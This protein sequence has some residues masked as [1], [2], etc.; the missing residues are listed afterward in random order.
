MSKRRVNGGVTTTPSSTITE[1]DTSISYVLKKALTT[2]SS[3]EDKVC[4]TFKYWFKIDSG[5]FFEPI[6]Q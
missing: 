4:V 3:W 6:T 1:E 5:N 2:D